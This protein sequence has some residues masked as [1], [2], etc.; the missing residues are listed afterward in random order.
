MRTATWDSGDP[1][2]YFDNPNLRWG[3]P[4]YLL[5]PGDPG[6][7]DPSPSVNT[8]KNK[9]TRM[10][11]QNYYP[12]RVADQIAWLRTFADKL[13]GKA[14]V[15]GLT[16]A[17]VTALVAD[18]L[19]LAYVLQNWLDAVRSFSLGC[20]QTANAA[21]TGTGGLVTLPGFTAPNL[22][23]NVTPQNEGSLTR[24]FAAVQDIKNG[25]KLTNAIAAELGIVGSADNGPDL[26]TVQPVISATASGSEV[27]IKWGWQG[28]RAWLDSCE[29]QVDRGD[30]KGF[31]LLTIDTTPNYT[32]TQTFPTAK[33]A[34]SYK[35]IYRVADKQT[36]L[37]SAT[38]S[39]AV[40]A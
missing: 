13:P 31:V 38:V 7:V 28:N 3:S 37:W 14:T 20:T 4:S 15:L 11:R 33:A 9:K 25:H 16:P 27:D 34:W 30:G 35:A 6:Y 17:T 12:S 32:D 5:E 8:T 39:V 21:Q 26:T 19:W 18:A 22:P 1:E 40:P 2:M 10:K 23:N 24:I 29:I 36:G